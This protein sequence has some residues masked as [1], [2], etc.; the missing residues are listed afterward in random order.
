MAINADKRTTAARAFVRS[1]NILLKFARM[2]DF[3]H[4]RTAKQYETAWT[5]LKTALGDN[6]AGLLLSVSGDQ[7]LLDG[8][9]IE[10][11]AAEKS[12]A[13]MLSASGIASIHFS[14]KVTQV[15]LAKFVRGFPTGSGA[16]PG[17]LAEQLK[18]AL[19]GDPNI[20]VNEVC[21]VPADSAVAKSTV[22][23]QLAAR[24]LGFT[25]GQSD[26]I[27]NDPE[28]LLQLIMA[29]EGKKGT[30]TGGPGMGPDGSGGSGQGDGSGGSGSGWGYGSGAGPGGEGSGPAGGYSGSGGQ[31]SEAWTGASGAAPSGFYGT[32]SSGAPGGGSLEGG[33]A[34][35]GAGPSGGAGGGAPGV[36]GGT[37]NIV[38][39][40][41]GGTPLD[42]NAGGFWLQREGAAPTGPGGAGGSG[43]GSGAG[44]TGPASGL[45]T[46]GG[47]GVAGPGA[48][49]GTGGS[50]SGGPG[51]GAGGVDAGTWNIVGG[52][53]GGA[54]LDPNAGGFWLQGQG[55]APGGPGAAGGSGTGSG[56][57]LSGP[58]AG[59]GVPGGPGVGGPGSGGGVGRPG[60]GG[61]GFGGPG[62]G[63]PGAGGA[64]P[65]GPGAGAPGSGGPGAG[66]FGPGKPG[67]AGGPGTAGRWS[68]ATSGI[69]ATRSARGGAGS[70]AVETGLMTL[71]E[72][73]LQGILQVLAQI[74]RTNE[75]AKDKLDPNAF[76][77]RLSTLPRRARF[78]VS[79]ALSAL[80][81]QAPNESSDKPTLLKLAEH[82]AVRFALESYERGD[83]KVNTVRQLLDE[84]DQ[85]LDSLRKILGIYEEKMARA[86]IEV[87]SHVDLLAQ[88]FWAHVSED[89]KKS[90]LESDDAWCVPAI[91]AR[92]YVEA[93]RVKGENE[94]ADKVLRNYAKGI[95]NKS[96]EPRRQTA[97]GLAELASVYAASD[98]KLFAETIR[99]IGV[100][101]AEETEPELQSLVGAA[102]VRFSQE[103]AK[104]RSF[105]GVQRSVE[106]MDYIEAERPGV[107]KNLRPRIQIENRLPEF[108]EEALRSG[109][110][111]SG[112]SDL[113][114]RLP[115]ISSQQ[116]ALRFSR[117]GF[118]ED[119]EVLVSM[120]EKLGPE[121]L[122]HLRKLLKE[123]SSSEA[124]DTVG[125]L[126]RMDPESVEQVLPARMQEWKR[127]A[128]DRIVRQIA[129]SGSSER[130]RLLL[131][132]FDHLDALIRPLAVDEIGMC[133]DRGADMRLLRIAEGD[134]PKE[135][136]PYLRLKAM[137][138]LGRLRTT[139][140]EAVLRKIAETRKAWRWANPSELRLVA[141]QAMEKIDPEWV[142]S[143]VPRSGLSIAEFS[144]EPLDADPESS[145]IRQRRYP[146]MRL[147]H[148]M[149]ATTT[150][151]KENCNAEIPEMTLGGGVAV[152]EQSLHPGSIVSFRL[153]AQKQTVKAQT[154]VRDANTQARAFEV[155]DMDLEER[156]KL[157]KILVQI[158]NVQ[159]QTTP[160]ERNRR[161]V[162]T[163]LSNPT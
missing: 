87:Q 22:A 161:A 143:F 58:G 52:S 131:E 44:L 123:G 130:G 134:V 64:R 27:F 13:R 11:A 96:P 6:E 98:E 126:V 112:L 132:L 163:I 139:G 101:L 68:N 8:T 76:Q 162:R 160:K 80:A 93:L 90:V 92:E 74:A 15:S 65:G 53:G 83:V 78:T 110:V 105:A 125:I 147:E 84:M 21:F 57:G 4:P 121:A 120:M 50:G 82:I 150:N 156:A 5:E 3:G 17:Q 55:A 30:G 59:V 48:I 14:P 81:A 99:E 51:T 49:G 2:Y 66:N 140:A 77:S 133:G 36:E 136:T 1:L 141:A 39:G 72:D 37:W 97:L 124:I 103:A 95:T 109:E 100:Q 111:P 117:A 29:A 32:G 28:K 114:R 7:L 69:R 23:Q 10:S 47:A 61:P 107:A 128:H 60:L 43:T 122:D 88:Q 25:A 129:S 41:G 155:V 46:P 67:G 157:R 158:G 9:P 18:Q 24:T 62:S 16:K 33:A 94:A 108:I 113:L 75:G 40:S 104:K 63:G 153:N 135:G 26:D 31:G 148:P 79:Q 118:R 127:T 119:C 144:I 71:H 12:F 102:F 86:G 20:H 145:A 106:L 151:L 159:K 38:G 42:P 34:Q 89:K 54:P 45:G 115:L 73:E 91:K 56:A 116:I 85:E 146:R 19:Q 138:A 35:V 149:S 70:M 142:R 154:I 152:C 137:E